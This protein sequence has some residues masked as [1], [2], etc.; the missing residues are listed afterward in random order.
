MNEITFK[1]A[2]PG[3]GKTQWLL[4][5]AH[6]YSKTHNVYLYYNKPHEYERFCDKYFATY[7]KRCP[8]STY[9][10]EVG[11]DVVVLVDDLFKQ[12]MSVGDIQHL[13]ANCYKVFITLTGNSSD[14]PVESNHNDPDQLTIDTLEVTNA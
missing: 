10:C 11:Q 14:C 5:V 1:V 2:H 6:E 13:Q 4:A 7:S 3:E 8:V 12:P 9:T